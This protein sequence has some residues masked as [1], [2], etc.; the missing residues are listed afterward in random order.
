MKHLIS[1]SCLVLCLLLAGCGH[2]EPDAPAQPAR[3]TILVYMI[4]S[5]SLGNNQRDQQDLAE[6]DAAV[7]QGT[8]DGCRLLV[9]RVGP[10]DE[11]PQLFEV[12]QGRAGEAVH[13]TLVTYDAAQQASVTVERMSRVI[14]DALREAP[15][16]DYGLV[17]WSHATGWAPALT[18]QPAGAAAPRRVFGEDNGATMPLHELA[19]AI[20]AGTFSWIYADVCYMGGIEVAYQLRDRCRWFAGYATEIPARGMPYDLTL[21]LLCAPEADLV[22]ACRATYEHYN[23]L[24]GQE[25]T[26]TGVVVDCSQLAAL[27]ALCRDIHAAGITPDLARVQCYNLRASRFLYDFLQYTQACCSGDDQ[28][29]QLHDLYNKVAVY[30]AATPWVFNRFV[31]D[32][33]RFSGLSTYAMGTSPGLN[34]DYYLTLDWYRDVY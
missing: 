31:I 18:T 2:D 17:L 8:L 5:N 19:Q 6:M 26:F 23:A 16:A 10:G 7:A 27:A 13:E 14:A 33:A 1:I 25:R 15:A 3:R 29:Q 9:Y 34:Q 4:A 24:T 21:P 30:R 11:A 20:P 28:L 32:T 12:R 22:G